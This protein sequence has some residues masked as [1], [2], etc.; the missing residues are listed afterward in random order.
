M[1]AGMVALSLLGTGFFELFSFLEKKTL[2]LKTYTGQRWIQQLTGMDQYCN[3]KEDGN[4]SMED[5]PGLAFVFSFCSID[6]E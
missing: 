1:Y 5:Q 2:S 4:T 3:K 6:S